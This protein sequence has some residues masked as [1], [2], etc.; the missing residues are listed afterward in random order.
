MKT[1]LF[2]PA[3]IIVITACSK[4]TLPVIERRTEEPP[5]PVVEVNIAA[6]E[7]LFI[8]RCARCHDLPKPSKYN[9]QRWDAIL[10]TM[11][12]RTNLSGSDA[13]AVMAYIKAN[14]AAD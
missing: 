2:I 13:R 5:A 7:K 1:F 9:T 4:K 6:G 8:T 10:S 14:C 12:P 3:V 11:I